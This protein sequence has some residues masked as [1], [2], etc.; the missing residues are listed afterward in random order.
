MT[1]DYPSQFD[2]QCPTCQQMGVFVL[3]GVQEWETAVAERAGLPAEIAL[4]TCPHCQ[5]TV[6]HLALLEEN[7]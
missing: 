2:A 1:T 4:Y 7:Y 6:S 3:L 5:T